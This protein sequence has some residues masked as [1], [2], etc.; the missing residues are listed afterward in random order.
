MQHQRWHGTFGHHGAQGLR[1]GLVVYRRS[2]GE[3][4]ELKRWLLRVLHREPPVGTVAHVGVHPKSQFADIKGQRLILVIHIQAHHSNATP[5]RT[6][7]RHHCSL[8]VDGWFVPF[9]A[10]RR[11]SETAVVRSGRCAAFR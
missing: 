4:T 6:L 3:Q 9:A 8:V 2:R 10:V 11:F 7:V 5:A 1:G